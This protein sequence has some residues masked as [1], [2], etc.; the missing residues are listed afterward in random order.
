M[1]IKDIRL[2]VLDMLEIHIW[3]GYIEHEE[4]TTLSQTIRLFV[5]ISF[6]YL[7]FISSQIY[8]I[9]I[10]S[11]MNFAAKFV[12]QLI[13]CTGVYWDSKL[14][15]ITFIIRS[16]ILILYWDPDTFYYKC[17]LL[18]APYFYPVFGSA[19]GTVLWHAMVT[20]AVQNGGHCWLKRR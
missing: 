9:I 17:S 12:C 6:C 18:G 3:K 14:L 16:S 10:S 5:G 20:K 7:P 8:C 1:L 4:I 19:T 13:C 2:S 15:F 11:T